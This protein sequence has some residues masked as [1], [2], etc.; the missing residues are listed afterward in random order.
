MPL[1]NNTS[2][3]IDE[4][5]LIIYL[6]RHGETQWNVEGRM[7]GWENSPLTSTGKQHAFRHGQLLKQEGVKTILASDSGRVRETVEGIRQSCDVEVT[8]FEQLRERNVGKWEG[9]R[10]VQLR[11]QYPAAWEKWSKRDQDFAPPNGESLGQMKERVSQMLP[12]L[13]DLRED[14]VAF[15]SH[16]I[17]TMVLIDLLFGLSKEQK[18]QL[19]IPHDVIHRINRR[20]SPA[21]IGYLKHDAPFTKGVNL[22]HPW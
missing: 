19:R 17:T 12:L 2:L 1:S 14:R 8:H 6:V 22:S 18:Q 5:E 7:Q 11:D 4:S 16:G 10:F 15:V 21:S 9:E 13:N 20:E 3:S